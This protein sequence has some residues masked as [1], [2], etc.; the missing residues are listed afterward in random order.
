MRREDLKSRKQF[1]LVKRSE[2]KVNAEQQYIVRNELSET[3][4]KISIS[5]PK[6]FEGKAT[7]SQFRVVDGWA[8]LKEHCFKRL[9]IQVQ[10][11]FVTIAAF[12]NSHEYNGF[13]Q[14]KGLF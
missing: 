6:I 10:G 3:I 7:I 2:F 9:P 13:L 12:P 5:D 11:S 4:A 1:L 14:C 8:A